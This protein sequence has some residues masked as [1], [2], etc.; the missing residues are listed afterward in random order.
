MRRRYG[1]LSTK[2]VIVIAA[3]NSDCHPERSEGSARWTSTREEILRFAQ[4]DRVK[5]DN[6]YHLTGD[7]IKKREH[8]YADTNY[9]GNLSTR[10]L[11][12]CA[13]AFRVI[14]RQVRAG[15]PGG[16]A[17]RVRGRVQ[18]SLQ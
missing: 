17:C 4:D 7:H 16:A 5:A 11:P 13:R 14:R 6:L 9:I 1:N 12:R 15:K 18:S 10:S 3:T 2:C 8:S